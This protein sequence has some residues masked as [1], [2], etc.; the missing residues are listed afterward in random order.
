MLYFQY[1]GNLDIVLL[2]SQDV[3]ISIIGNLDIVLLISQNVII[4][5]IGNLDIV[6]LISQ[7]VIVS[8]IGNLDIVLLISQDV[9]ISNNELTLILKI[10]TQCDIKYI[11]DENNDISYRGLNIDYPSSSYR[12]CC[13]ISDNVCLYLKSCC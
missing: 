5:I 4:S 1:I 2:I 10:I 13:N 7:D 12:I 11:T 9:I 8:I 3:I 6:L